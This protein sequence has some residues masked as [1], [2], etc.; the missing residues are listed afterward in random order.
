LAG[1]LVGA[2]VAGA[3]WLYTYQAHDVIRFIDKNGVEYNDPRPVSVQP[4]WGIYAAL[5]VLAIAVAVAIRLAPNGVPT[6]N[7]LR[8]RIFSSGP[9]EPRSRNA[10][11]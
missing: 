11:P 10:H 5:A 7:R 2:S 8:H 1:V 4:W 9:D 3:V 6:M